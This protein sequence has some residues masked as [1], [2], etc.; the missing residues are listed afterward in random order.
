MAF[1][2]LFSGKKPL[3]EEY[4][5]K[6]QMRLAARGLMSNHERLYENTPAPIYESFDDYCETLA[7][8]MDN[9]VMD[10]LDEERYAKAEAVADDDPDLLMFVKTMRICDTY[11]DMA[12]EMDIPIEQV[13]NLS[14]KLRRRLKKAGYLEI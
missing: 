11:D 6:S 12:E 8:S 14:R 9:T 4:T 7:N 3:K 10:P 13:Y 2:L 5:L 1:D